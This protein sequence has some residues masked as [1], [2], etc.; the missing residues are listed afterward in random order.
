M[1]RKDNATV[2]E[3]AEEGSAGTKI[4]VTPGVAKQARTLRE[5]A[6]LYRDAANALMGADERAYTRA[7]ELI[8]QYQNLFNT[9]AQNTS[10]A[11]TAEGLATATQE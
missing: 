7:T 9:L 11:I 1:A 10:D 8:A 2:P 5:I 6:T 4:K 3:V